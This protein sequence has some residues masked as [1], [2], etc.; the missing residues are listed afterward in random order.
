MGR[1]GDVFAVITVLPSDGYG[2]KPGDGPQE[3][4]VT[5]TCLWTVGHRE[6]GVLEVWPD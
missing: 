4:Q 1:T 2:L 3:W 6:L 5:A